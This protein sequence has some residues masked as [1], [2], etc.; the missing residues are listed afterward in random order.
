MKGSFDLQVR[1]IDCEIGDIFETQTRS[2]S[3]CT[4]GTFTID[5]PYKATYCNECPENLECF[6]GSKVGPMPGYWMYNLKALTAIKCPYSSA[7]LY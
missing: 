1:F 5:D 7:C 2:C 6:G 3:V 4:A